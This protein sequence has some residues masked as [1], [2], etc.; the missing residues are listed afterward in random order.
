LIA[1]THGV[2]TVP[3]PLVC[4]NEMIIVSAWEGQPPRLEAAA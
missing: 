3:N 2:D 4:G 1:N